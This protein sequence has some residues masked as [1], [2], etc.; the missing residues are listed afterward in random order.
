V[1]GVDAYADFI[2]EAGRREFRAPADGGWTA[3]QIVAHVASTNEQLITTTEAVLAGHETSY[4]N[5]EAIGDRALHAYAASY[6]G[7]RGLA[8]RV[9]ETVAVLRDLA[10][11]LSSRDE[12]LVPTRIQDGDRVIV[13]APTPW[14]QVLLTNATGHT[15]QH[16]DQLRALRDERRPGD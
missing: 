16:L 10:A 6:G 3:E 4:D 11:Q 13:D 15:R 14:G 2:E 7:L 1:Q 9:A 5:R 12:V 8:D